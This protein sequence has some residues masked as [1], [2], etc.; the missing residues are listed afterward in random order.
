MMNSNWTVR[1]DAKSEGAA[2]RTIAKFES[3]V[4]VQ[5]ADLRVEEHH[6]GGHIVYFLVPVSAAEWKEAVFETLEI[7]QRI[8]YGWSLLGSV[9][10]EP[11]GFCAKFRV[12]GVQSASWHLT[13]SL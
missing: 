4:G 10:D 9:L 3:E 1:V 11:E 12:S 8:G 5:F 6:E 7:A 2:R 13:R